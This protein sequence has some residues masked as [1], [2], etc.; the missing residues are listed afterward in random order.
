[1]AKYPMK[2]SSLEFF[3][4]ILTNPKFKFV[5]L[6]YGKVQ[7]EVSKFNQEHGTDIIYD[8]SVN[9][10]VDMDYWLSQVAAMD[11]V[12]TVANTTVHG[13]AGLGVPT[14]VLVS[15]NSDWRWLDH[16]VSEDC[17]W[18]DSVSTVHQRFR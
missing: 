8:D 15:D 7:E 11:A 14:C 10:L 2:S 6:H 4:P 18:Y 12:L 3:L 9:S 13:A 17:L 1:M 16:T 5:S